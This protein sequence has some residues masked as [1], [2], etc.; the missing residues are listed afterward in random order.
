M[1]RIKL[2][3]I[4]A[5]TLY[6]GESTSSRRGQSIPQ[7]VCKGKPCKLFTPDVIRCVNLGGEGTDVD[8]KVCTFPY[9]WFSVPSSW[10][11]ASVKRIFLSLCDWDVS[12]CRVRGGQA[13]ETRMS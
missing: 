5:L 1:S 12:K 3:D 11:F 10:R 8:W 9:T 6:Q 7:L 4:S 2:A 13:R